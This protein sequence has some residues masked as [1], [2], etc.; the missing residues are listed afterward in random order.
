MSEIESFLS[1][2][3]DAAWSTHWYLFSSIFN[4]KHVVKVVAVVFL[5]Y[6]LI[7]DYTKHH[8]MIIKLL[9]LQQ[10]VA[11]AN[12]VCNLTLILRYPATDKN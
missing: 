3:L 6:Y 9:P 7:I 8:P 1:Y 5:P 2:S 10:I 12:Y 4:F 11:E